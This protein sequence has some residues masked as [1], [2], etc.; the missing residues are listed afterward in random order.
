M[1]PSNQLIGEPLKCSP[2]D[3]TLSICKFTGLSTGILQYRGEEPIFRGSGK[4][5]KN[6]G[7][8]GKWIVRFNPDDAEVQSPRPSKRGIIEAAS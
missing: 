8:R 1:Q 2:L 7:R 4:A 5:M 6:G 3:H